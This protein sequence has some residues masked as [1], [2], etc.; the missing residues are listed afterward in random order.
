M[1]RIYLSPHFDDAAFSCG[2][3]I[4]EQVQKG[5]QV[6]VITVCAGE[7]PAGPISDYAQ[8]LHDR[9]ETGQEAVSVRRGEN[10]RSCQILGARVINLTIPDVI[11]RRSPVDGSPICEFDADLTAD[12]RDVEAPLIETLKVELEESIPPDSEI[13]SPLALGGHVDHRLVRAAVEALGRPVSYFADFPY[14]V[15]MNEPQID[16][17]RE[18]LHNLYPISERGLETWQASIAA[19]DSQ[20]STFWGSLGQMREAVQ[21]YWE[22]TRGLVIWYFP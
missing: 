12:L 8:S 13:V 9:W 19:H 1:K 3:L 15:D 11:Y 17:E 2:G 20:I 10:R 22:P 21:A 18:M 14:L 5:D 6:S 7:P 4:W 16:L